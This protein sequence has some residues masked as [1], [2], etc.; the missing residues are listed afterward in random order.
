MKMAEIKSPRIETYITTYLLVGHS[1]Y[2]NLLVGVVQQ[3]NSTP[4]RRTSSSSLNYI[5]VLHLLVDFLLVVH[6][7]GKCSVFLTLLV[8]Q[9]P[10]QSCLK[11]RT[12]SYTMPP[13]STS[14][15]RTSQARR[16]GIFDNVSRVW[17]MD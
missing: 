11:N 8:V 16:L 2:G 13:R 7:I 15:S 6:S 17:Y 9:S 1:S 4:R 12:L 5:V 10:P 3:C 14:T